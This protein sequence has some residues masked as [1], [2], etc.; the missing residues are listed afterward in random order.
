MCWFLMFVHY[1]INEWSNLNLQCHF[2]NMHWRPTSLILQIFYLEISTHWISTSLMQR[3]FNSI[4]SI[5]QTICTK[6]WLFCVAQLQHQ[7]LTFTLKVFTGLQN[8]KKN[9]VVF[10]WLQI[11][12]ELCMYLPLIF[13]FFAEIPSV[14][15]GFLS[16]RV[17][18]WPR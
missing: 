18:K 11:C 4:L 14:C 3:S 17:S 13:T 16:S 5:K 10:S 12:K 15:R 6:I 7:I 2:W 8:E 9:H 1:I